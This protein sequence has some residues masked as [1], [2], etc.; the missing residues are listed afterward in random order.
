MT[1]MGV[2]VPDKFLQA[3]QLIELVRPEFRD[4]IV[5]SGLS[6]G[7][8]L[9]A[10]AAIQAS[11]PVRTIVFDPLGLNGNMMGKPGWRPFGQLEKLSDRFRSMDDF[12]DWYYIANSWVAKLNVKRHLSSVGRVTELPQDP[13]RARNNPDTH[14]FRLVRF[15][16]HQ[17]WDNKGWR[18]SEISSPNASAVH[19]GGDVGRGGPVVRPPKSRSRRLPCR[20]LPCFA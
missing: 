6:L 7:G 12:V 1:V 13:V 11:W 14:D 18:G 15:G 2:G 9:S 8:G 20:E 16:L 5:L 3:A 10:Y 19:V 17:L 4:K